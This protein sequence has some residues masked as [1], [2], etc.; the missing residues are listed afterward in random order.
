[1]GWIRRVILRLTL[2]LTVMTALAAC[3][4]LT[5]A[6]SVSPARAA[7]ES[8][9]AA[10]EAR[11]FTSYRVALRVE[12]LGKICY[13]Q[14]EVRGEWVRQT[15]RNTCDSIWLDVMTI[16][17][18]FELSGEIEELP[19]S[20]CAP[21]GKDC[22]CHRVFTERQVAYDEALGYP[23]TVLARSEMRYNWGNPELW[24]SIL[25]ESEL[26][27]CP[28]SRRRLTVQVLALTPID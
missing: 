26:P 24:Q 5:A 3:A 28:P 21:S 18:L 20:R 1:M 7:R 8:A 2:L 27:R 15:L 4:M 10:W 23:T 22:P 19:P 16:D 14:L 12:A 6:A 11:G 13:Q 9:L 17:Q 25:Q